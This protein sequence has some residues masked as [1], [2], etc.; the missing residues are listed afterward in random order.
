MI[1]Y[2]IG[3][4]SIHELPFQPIPERNHIVF[5][6][7]LIEAIKAAITMEQVLQ[8]YGLL[9]R[10]TKSRNGLIGPCPIHKGINPKQFHICISKNTWNCF[11]ECKHGGNVLDFIAILENIRIHA[12]AVKAIEWFKL[13]SDVVSAES[14]RP[15]KSTKL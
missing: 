10:F 11:G 1:G 12:A 4:D 15:P 9:D 8:H 3:G 5:Q 14:D 7:A 13:D 6:S 2:E